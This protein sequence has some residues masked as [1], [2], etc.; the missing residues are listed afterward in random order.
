MAALL[1]C[2]LSPAVC[3]A[4]GRHCLWEV[5]GQHNT[6]YLLGSVH[7]LRIADSALPPPILAAYSRSS[8]LM[9]ELDLNEAGGDALLGDEMEATLLPEGESLSS[10]IGP[11]LNRD[12]EARARPLGLEPAVTE[13]FQPWFAALM[14]QQLAL[15]Q[16][17][18]ETGA[19]I[20]MQMAQRAQADHK[21][22][23]A[24]ETIAEQLGYFANLSLEQQRQFLRATLKGLDTERSDMA[25]LVSA[26]QNGDTGELERLMHK[27]AQE[28]PE[29]FRQLTTERNRRWLPKITA[30]LE[31]SHDHLVI[32][33]AMH[34]I[35][36]DGIV[37]LL[38]RQGHVVE[39]Q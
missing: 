32:V 1:L 20:D 36:D 27:D 7:M 12:F 30:L 35:G 29:L 31:D 14:I 10:T 13:R 4:A 24:L 8:S 19:G 26:W 15:A 37:Q 17:G 38:R 39:Q 21:P 33:G 34:L 5:R 16:S 3:L 9:M 18:F 6:V 25:G 2:W 22:V 23:I 11:E 28:S